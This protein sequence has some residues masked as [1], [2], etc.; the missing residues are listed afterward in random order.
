MNKRTWSSDAQYYWRVILGSSVKASHMLLLPC[1]FARWKKS[2]LAMTN[3]VPHRAIVSNKTLIKHLLDWSN[4]FIN[5]FLL[6]CQIWQDTPK[7]YN[8][9]TI[10]RRLVPLIAR[11]DN[12]QTA[13]FTLI[14][15]LHQFVLLLLHTKCHQNHLK[16]NMIMYTFYTQ[17]LLKSV[18]MNIQE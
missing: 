15:R 17:C 6:I 7:L 10:P 5:L 2:E 11:R 9:L 4:P 1:L 18:L 3:R 14:Y 16:E 13:Y 12:K 8:L